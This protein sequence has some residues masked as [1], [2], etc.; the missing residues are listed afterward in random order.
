MIRSVKAG[1]G[2]LRSS[3]GVVTSIK[4]GMAVRIGKHGVVRAVKSGLIRRRRLECGM[5]VA[6]E[7]RDGIAHGFRGDDG[8][9]EMIG[10]NT[11]DDRETRRCRV[12]FWVDLGSRGLAGKWRHG[13]RRIGTNSPNLEAL[14]E[15]IHAR[16]HFR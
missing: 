14:D 5:I 12:R 3:G 2:I 13:L 15:L 8:D 9:W 11:G 10:I 1:V 6:V 7:T 4:P 16:L